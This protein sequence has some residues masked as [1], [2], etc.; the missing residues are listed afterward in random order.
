MTKEEI[1]AKLDGLGI[2]FGAC[3]HAF[4][5]DDDDPFVNAAY[6]MYVREGEVEIDSPTVTSPS[7]E[8][9]YV[10]AWVWVGNEDAGIQ[11]ED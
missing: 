8:G 3:V 6:E 7:D 2:G 4:A 1:R 10:L 5:A 11:E 9:A